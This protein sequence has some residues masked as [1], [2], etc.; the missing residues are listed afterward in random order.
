MKKIKLSTYAKNNNCSYVTAYTYY[1][2]GVIKGEQL[3]TGTILIH[4]EDDKPI[5]P[6]K[7]VIYCRESSSENKSS[8]E[9]QTRRLQDYCAAKGWNI[10]RTVKE[11]GS[12]L[13]DK[14]QKFLS[15]LEDTS[16]TKIVVEH[17]D[18]FCRFG[19]EPIK[20]LL[21]NQNRELII[22]NKSNDDKED[23]I[24]DFVSIITSFCA[25]IYGQRRTKKATEQLIKSLQN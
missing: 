25:R 16:I 11:I 12:G 14:R 18:R 9:N 7:V 4:D 19:L 5:I 10:D 23:L 8:L 20:T 21:K 17:S 2:N 22:V 13:N 6:E 15:I 24:E 1:K 3:P